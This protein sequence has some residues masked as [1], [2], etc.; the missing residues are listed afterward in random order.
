MLLRGELGRNQADCRM[1]GQGHRCPI[2]QIIA[3]NLIWQHG[4]QHAHDLMAG[5]ERTNHRQAVNPG[6]GCDDWLQVNCRRI[7]LLEQICDDPSQEGLA[8]GEYER[9]LRIFITGR[10]KS[11]EGVT[12]RLQQMHRGLHT[13]EMG[14]HRPAQYSGDR[15][16]VVGVGKLLS[17]LFQ[18]DQPLIGLPGH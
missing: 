1:M 11:I 15:L 8:Y 13:F 16:D 4:M 5:N 6:M 17:D 2:V 7:R 12:I 9:W 3:G 10:K 18:G 14:E